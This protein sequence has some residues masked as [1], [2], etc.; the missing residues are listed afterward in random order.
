MRTKEAIE[1]L[2]QIELNYPHD[3]EIAHSRAD[4]VLLDYLD[5]NG[6]TNLTEVYRRM[7][8]EYPFWYA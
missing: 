4:N 1:K 7:R 2:E 5:A 6:K 3:S 8:N